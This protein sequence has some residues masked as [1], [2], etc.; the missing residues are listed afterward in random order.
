MCC[1]RMAWCAVAFSLLETLHRCHMLTD[2]AAFLPSSALSKEIDKVARLVSSCFA[3]PS[4]SLCG[5]MN[6]FFEIYVYEL[7]QVRRSEQKI[8][9]RSAYRQP[10]VLW[11]SLPRGHEGQSRLSK[12][13]VG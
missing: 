12:S 1:D 6:D 11:R 4:L 8:S 7:R 2:H 5:K 9:S 10:L 13:P 3:R